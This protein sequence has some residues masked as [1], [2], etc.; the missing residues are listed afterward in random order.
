MVDCRGSA[1]GME[2]GDIPGSSITASSWYKPYI[3]YRPDA[4]R[5]NKD[6]ETWCPN[7]DDKEPY[8]Q[9][10]FSQKQEVSG[11]CSSSVGMHIF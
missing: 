3:S 2:N 6:N 9:V 4:G 5:L 1:L 8:L 11:R 7:R 10:E